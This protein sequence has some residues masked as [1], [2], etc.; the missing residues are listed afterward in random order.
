MTHS[1]AAPEVK[2]DKMYETDT[3]IS[4]KIHV[5]MKQCSHVYIVTKYIKLFD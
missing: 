2:G 3:K 4:I 1:Y 5:L